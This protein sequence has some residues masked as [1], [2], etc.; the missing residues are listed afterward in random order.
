MQYLLKSVLIKLGAES[1]KK[2]IIL[3]IGI[4]VISC[5]GLKKA[6]QFFESEDYEL[7]IQECQQAIAK[8]SLNA[9]A[10]FIMGKSY[11]ALGKTDEAMVSLQKA[12]QVQPHSKVT[13]SA[14]DEIITIH[15]NNANGFLEQKQYNRAITTFQEII[16]LDSTRS[17]AYFKLGV[18]YEQNGL[19]D[20]AKFYFE[21]AS[22]TDSANRLVSQK[23][24]SLDSL[25]QKAEAYYQKGKQFYLANNYSSAIKY[26]KLALADKADHQDAKYYYHMAEGKKL[27]RKGSKSNCWDA[28]GHYGK[29]MIIRSESAEPHFFMALAYEKK[30]REEFD[31]AID[32][33]SI[34]VEKEPNGAYANQS[35]KKIR[36][37]KARR[38]KLKKF[39]GK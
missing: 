13:G 7:A 23:I 2:W 32:E 12:F 10:Y 3:S 1:M 8:D 20:K 26:L 29:A 33:Y 22:Q 35:K 28:I 19:L 34:S 14:K 27:Y 38:D 21:K 31:N 39:W 4:V 36:E 15:F 16:D 5:A 11:K 9:E 37:L 6:N 18:C 17:D 30:D 25:S 24:H